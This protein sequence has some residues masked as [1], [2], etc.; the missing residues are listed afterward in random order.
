MQNTGAEMLSSASVW[1]GK[2]TAVYA[3]A[4]RSIHIPM[5]VKIPVDYHNTDRL[6]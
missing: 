6:S 2:E 1:K 4:G 5:N 3:A